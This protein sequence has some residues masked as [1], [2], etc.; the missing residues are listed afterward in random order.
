VKNFLDE[1]S[2]GT[3]CG[4]PF[5]LNRVDLQPHFF[6][7]ASSSHH[8]SG[9]FGL[10]VSPEPWINAHPRCDAAEN[11]KPSERA[12]AVRPCG[13]ETRDV[14]TKRPFISA[15]AEGFPPRTNSQ[16]IM[17]ANNA[18]SFSEGSSGRDKPK[19]EANQPNCETHVRASGECEGKI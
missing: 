16:T 12:V 6:G 10:G 3:F 4:A 5:S 15:F 19:E 13:G 9:G 8:F 18:S 2:C 14:R 1:E 17:I 11:T 7:K